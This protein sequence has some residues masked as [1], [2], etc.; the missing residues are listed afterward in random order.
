MID[1]TII[2]NTNIGKI[3]DYSVLP[4]NT[5][6][7]EIRNGCREAVRY[8]CA[9]FYTA[10]PY[11]TPIVVEELQGTDVRAATAADVQ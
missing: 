6:E 2:D 4:K 3:F 8:N 10:S 1:L 7:S 11:W 9:A 5:T